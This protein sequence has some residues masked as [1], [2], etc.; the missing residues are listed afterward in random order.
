MAEDVLRNFFIHQ[1]KIYG[2][3]VSLDLEAGRV[4]DYF[5]IKEQDSVGE[6]IAPQ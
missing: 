3:A 5:A 2:N 4:D 6:R 1:E